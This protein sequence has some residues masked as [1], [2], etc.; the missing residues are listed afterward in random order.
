MSLIQRENSVGMTKGTTW[1]SPIKPTGGTGLYVKAHTPPKGAR[2]VITNE[3]EFGRG[4]ASSAEILE[5]EAQSGSMSMR[6]Y[7]EGLEGIIASLMGIYSYD[8]D[9]PLEAGVRQHTFELDTVIGSIFHTV[10]WDE[11][12][13]I[14]A[15]NS[16][17]VVSG[18]FSYQDGL[19][20]DV[21]YMGDKVSISGWTSPLGVSYPSDGTGMFKLSNAEVLINDEGGAALGSGDEL[22]PSGIDIAITRGLEGLPVVAGSE[23]I[24]EPI[25]K[26]APIVEVTLTFPKKE[27]ATAAYFAAF[28]DRTFKKMKVTFTGDTISGKTSKYLMELNFPRLMLM[29]APDF[30]QD[31]PIPT[32]IKL[33]ALQTS[34][35]PGNMT[36]TVPYIMLQN[37]VAELSNYPTS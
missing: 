8:E 14:K 15:V 10:A 22:N 37:T 36:K 29:E 20:L 23:T 3:D 27:T 18:T 2:K 24:T 9:P 21:N 28:N 32:T 5:Y 33:K 6:V 31:T 25:E 30:A 7:A 13:E 4:M 12:D 35:A 16:A 1:G 11:G 19:S 17:S 34:T 26:A